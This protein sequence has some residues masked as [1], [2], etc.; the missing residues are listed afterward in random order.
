MIVQKWI[1]ISI[2]LQAACLL[3]VWEISVGQFNHYII[4]DTI[5]IQLD[6]LGYCHSTQTY[7]LTWWSSFLKSNVKEQNYLSHCTPEDLFW[8]H[9]SREMGLYCCTASECIH[10]CSKAVRV[11]Q[12]LRCSESGCVDDAVDLAALGTLILP[13]QVA[14]Q[15]LSTESVELFVKWWQFLFQTTRI[16]VRHTIALPP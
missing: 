4:L 15:V 13:L 2:W 1:S 7:A 6:S 9:K 5:L 14:A 16:T 11:L 3:H 8:H 10:W 12:S